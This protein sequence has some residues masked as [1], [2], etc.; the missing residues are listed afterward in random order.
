MLKHYLDY[1]IYIYIY[2]NYNRKIS[3]VETAEFS[4]VAERSFKRFLQGKTLFN[5]N[6]LKV[7]PPSKATAVKA[8]CQAE[9]WHTLSV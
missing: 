7:W 6:A 1:L 9:I 2:T 5:H 8:L 4:V 3:G